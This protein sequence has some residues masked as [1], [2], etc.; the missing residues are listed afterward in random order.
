METVF[1]V[2]S[3]LLEVGFVFFLIRLIW[4]MS[5]Y[6]FIM[7]G[8]IGLVLILIQLSVLSVL[9]PYRS[10]YGNKRSWGL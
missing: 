9:F 6:L 10:F 8:I 7:H 1:W 5:M 3:L 2:L 4:N